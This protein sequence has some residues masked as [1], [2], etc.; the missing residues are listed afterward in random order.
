[1]DSVAVA[2]RAIRLEELTKNLILVSAILVPVLVGVTAWRLSRNQPRRPRLERCE[3]TVLLA[4]P[5]TAA[6]FAFAVCTG[7][8]IGESGKVRLGRAL[9]TPIVS[10]LE[11]YQIATGAYPDSLAKLVPTYVSS[12]ALHAPD[13]L[14]GRSF[15]YARDSSGFTLEF[16][17]FGPGANTCR[18]SPRHS[19]ACGGTY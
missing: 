11:R 7:G 12:T 2:L 4:I 6:A 18:H 14:L 17:Y 5:Y 8:A 9:A 1:M 15:G 3:H 10:G 19:W 16:Y 13:S